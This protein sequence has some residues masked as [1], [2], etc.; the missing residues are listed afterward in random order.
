[1]STLLVNSNCDKEKDEFKENLFQLA[2][3]FEKLPK[4]SEPITSS[5]GPRNSQPVPKE[6]HA[7]GHTHGHAH[8]GPMPPPKYNYAYNVDAKTYSGPLKFGQIE[9]RDGYKTHGS[10][11]V[12]LPDGRTQTVT[13]RVDDKYGGFIA[14]VKYHGTSHYGPPPA[15]YYR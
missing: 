6:Q 15:Y 12:L 13:Y 14:D 10:Y 5:E 3:E 2:N 11:H 9:N 8:H 7:H 1:M 4:Q